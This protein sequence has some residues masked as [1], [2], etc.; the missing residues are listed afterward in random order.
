LTSVS[1]SNSLNSKAQENEVA[2]E[3]V[4]GTKYYIAP[5]IV[6]NSKFTKA[7]DIWSLGVIM[8]ILLTGSF[9][10]GGETSEEFFANVLVYDGPLWDSIS[11]EAKDLLS[12]MLESE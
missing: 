1:P 4:A 7:C 9:P 11:K 2:L 8:Y 12:K 3:R 10:I 6:R 5:E